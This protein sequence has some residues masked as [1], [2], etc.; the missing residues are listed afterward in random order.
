MNVMIVG[1]GKVGAEL[2]R[3]LLAGGHMIRLLEPRPEVRTR[4][5]HELPAQTIV[6]GSGTDPRVLEAAGIRTTDVVAAVTGADEVNLVVASLAR[7]EFGVRRTI[8]RVNNPKN[9][10]LFTTEMGVDVALNQAELI[11]HLIVDDM[12]SYDKPAH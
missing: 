7:F 6:G 2:A 3:L 9:A 12:N 10:W 1:G 4:L 8:G 5:Q 11:S